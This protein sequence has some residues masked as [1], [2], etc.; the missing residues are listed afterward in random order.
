MVEDKKI[1]EDIGK[2]LGVSIPVLQ[3]GQMGFGVFYDNNEAISLYLQDMNLEICPEL[4]GNLKALQILDLMGN[5]LIS[6]PESLGELRSLRKLRLVSNNLEK[7]PE[8]IGNL[9][10]LTLLSLTKNNLKSLPDSFTNLTLL[11]ELELNRNEIISLS[12]NFGNLKSLKKLSL[13]NNIL[14][15]LPESFG[16]L[17]NLQKLDLRDNNLTNLPNSFGN[18]KMLDK[19]ELDN[20][21]LTS[22]PVTL[23][24]LESLKYL[25]L[26]NNKL[27]II[28]DSFKEMKNLG[29]FNI[30][31]NHFKIIPTLTSCKTLKNIILNDNPLIYNEMNINTYNDFYNKNIKIDCEPLKILYFENIKKSEINIIKAIM[32]MNTFLEL[33]IVW[34]DNWELKRKKNTF[35]VQYKENHIVQIRCEQSYL[36]SL[37]DNFGNLKELRTLYLGENNLESL[38]ES[39]G[40][41]I[42]LEKLELNNNKLTSLPESFVNLTEIKELN[43]S[44]NLFTEIPTVLWPLKIITE[45]NLS[46][47]P[48]N[49]ENLIVSKKIPEL[50]LKYLRKN[51]TIKVFISHAIIDFEPYRIEELVDYLNKQKE[52]SQ[53]YFCEADLAGNID[54][55]ML[56]TVQ[57]CQLVL[58]IATKKSIFDSVDCANELQLADKFSIP[59][60]P[61]KGKDVDWPDLAERKLSRELGIEY[62]IDNF[63]NFCEDLYK[64]IYGFKREIDLMGEEERVKSIIDIYEKFRL[65]LNESLDELK[66]DI[67]A[68]T[69]ENKNLAEKIAL[70]EKKFKYLNPF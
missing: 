2:I 44:C 40:N 60:I 52:I 67:E 51:A 18:L 63:N 66:R 39:F 26:A 50:I 8:S 37:P 12:E 36:K 45:L 56:E 47:N 28:P 31:G 42:N 38:P 1:I 9:Q 30:S 24:N 11:E 48:L 6:L 49:P 23:K 25:L 46:E 4:I 19:L 32:Q 65:I 35:K 62:D 54:K 57:K 16:E 43:L 55:W 64:Y 61:I 53:V 5:K 68:L 59:I 22:L 29:W 27:E 70:L 15:S 69:Y 17:E 13:R 33:I 58:F 20:N 34:G 7:L 41:L 3:H 21:N 14:N 10:N